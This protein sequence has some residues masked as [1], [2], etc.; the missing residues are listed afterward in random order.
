MSPTRQGPHIQIYQDQHEMQPHPHLHQHPHMHAQPQLQPPPLQ[1]NR[2]RPQLA[3]SAMPLQPTNRNAQ[4]AFPPPMH[5]APKQMTPILGSSYP[6][7]PGEINAMHMA[8]SMS[9]PELMPAFTDSPAKRTILPS[10]QPMLPP[11]IIACQ[12]MHSQPPQQPMFASWNSNLQPFDQE[13][14]H[15]NM[16][17]A[18]N[19]VEFPNS[20]GMPRGP[21]KRSYSETVPGS[22]KP[23]KK[24]RPGSFQDSEDTIT[25][26]PE[27]E[28]MP[29]VHDDG[30]KPPFSYA[31]MI[32]MAILRAENRQLTL[33]NIYQWIA[34]T[35][36]Y[37]REDP[38]TGWHNSIRHNLSLN[39]AFTKRERPKTDAGKG[40]YWV[41]VPGMEHLFFKDKNKKNNNVMPMQQA[42]ST[43]PMMQTMPQP[44]P[45]AMQTR[46]WIVQSQ[47]TM[48]TVAS[49]PQPRPQTAPALDVTLP[50]LSSDATLPASDPALN[51][52]DIVLSREVPNL[53]PP[54]MAPPPSSPPV[55]N[56]SPPIMPRQHHRTISSPA[57]IARPLHKR[58]QTTTNDDSGYFS[59][60]ESSARRP[61]AAGMM[62]TSELGFVPRRKN[63]R[64]EDAIIRMRSS[65]ITPGERRSRRDATQAL[66]SSSPLR[67]SPPEVPATPPVVFK[68][69]YLPPQSISPNS[70]LRRHREERD[71]VFASFNDSPLKQNDPFTNELS[72][73]SPAF[74]LDTPGLSNNIFD[75]NSFLDLGTAPTPLGSSPIK[76]S[77]SRP[78]LLRSNTSAGVLTDAS[79]RANRMVKTPSKIP[80]NVTFKAPATN[81]AGSPLKKTV[82]PKLDFFDDFND[83]NAEHLF[84]F[85]SFPEEASDEGE[86]LDISKGFSKIGASSFTSALKKPS[87]ARTQSSR[88]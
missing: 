48:E 57:R 69:P 41:I 23:F 39:K 70:Q 45:E 36:A 27:P 11:H 30:Q 16:P 26:L 4:M 75:E 20:S 42:F 51:E 12:A 47:A 18:A 82:T 62:P 7:M 5:M 37:Y 28:D 6:A 54:S 29:P 80:D 21:L 55:I 86:E 17:M 64:A 63:G 88:F 59:S 73:Y 61:R 67:Q 58:S 38:K 81:Y 65:S 50:S 33:A 19:F 15:V 79:S 71:A 40:C 22:D 72:T 31:T 78:S 13:N 46:G 32:G 77:M 34:D 53:E 2:P 9:Q 8:Q 87:L 3:P 74:K 1:L 10:S 25:E 66:R 83:E 24:G 35:F 60:L 52:D 68:K 84:D 49:V 85:T 76:P 43:Q 44:V 14:F 56:S